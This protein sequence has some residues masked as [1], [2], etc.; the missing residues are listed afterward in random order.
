[1]TQQRTCCMEGRTT[2]YGPQECSG[3]IAFIR[4]DYWLGAARK[5]NGPHA[6]Y[7]EAHGDFTSKANPLSGIEPIPVVKLRSV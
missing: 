7:C 5:V 4:R 6:Y 1:M 3:R 2:K